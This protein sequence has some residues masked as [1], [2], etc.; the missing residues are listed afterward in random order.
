MRHPVVSSLRPD[1]WPCPCPSPIPSEGPAG[2]CGAGTLG[3]THLGSATAPDGAAVH[4]YYVAIAARSRPWLTRFFLPWD[5][6]PG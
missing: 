2:D 4:R 1:S 5:R 3:T 6:Q